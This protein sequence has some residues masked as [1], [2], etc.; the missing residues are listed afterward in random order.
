MFKLNKKR[1]SI[2]AM[3]GAISG[4]AVA[5]DVI[6]NGTT[7]SCT[8]TCNVTFNN[9]SA[10]ITDSGGGSITYQQG[11]ITS[12]ISES[13]TLYFSSMMMMMGMG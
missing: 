10:V 3:I 8:N 6:I 5:D 11:N 1:F 7:Y 9:G 12:T 13:I 2:M 4:A